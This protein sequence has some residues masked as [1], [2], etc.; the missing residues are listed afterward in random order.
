MEIFWYWLIR[1]LVKMAGKMDKENA[2]STCLPSVMILQDFYASSL[3]VC[4]VMD[5]SKIGQKTC[6]QRITGFD[7]RL[8]FIGHVVH[9]C[10]APPELGLYGALCYSNGLWPYW[11]LALWRFLFFFFS[12]LCYWP[13]IP[14]SIQVRPEPMKGSQGRSLG[15]PFVFF[16]FLRLLFHQP[17]FSDVNKTKFLRPRPKPLFTRPRPKWQDQDQDHRK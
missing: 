12:F 2:Q 7:S 17:C 1:V 5:E 3:I 14:R 15:Y 4:W 11:G 6:N 10:P 13:I 9:W 16:V 8:D